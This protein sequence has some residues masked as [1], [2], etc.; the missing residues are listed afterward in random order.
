[1][2]GSKMSNNRAEPKCPECGTVGTDSIVSRESQMQ[3]RTREPWFFVIHCAN[4][5]Y[6]YNVITKHV[7][8]Q[9]STRVVLPTDNS[10]S[11][12]LTET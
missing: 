12:T 1:M 7:F 6:V 3:S 9:T 5:G 8:A 10:G 4:C 2:D 11:R